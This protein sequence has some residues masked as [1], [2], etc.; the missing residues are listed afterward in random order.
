MLDHLIDPDDEIG[1]E[2]KKV[3][4]LEPYLKDEIE[5]AQFNYECI[6]YNEPN[7]RIWS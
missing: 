2:P 6:V 3:W 4:D 1:C 5:R 7:R